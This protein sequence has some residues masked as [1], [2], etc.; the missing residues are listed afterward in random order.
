MIFE[1]L[2]EPPDHAV[3]KHTD[4]LIGEYEYV[5]RVWVGMKKPEVKDLLQERIGAPPGDLLEVVTLC[6]E[7]FEC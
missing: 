5:A 7:L 6:G 2:A 4:D 3:V 1:V